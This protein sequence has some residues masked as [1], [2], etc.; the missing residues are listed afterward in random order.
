[1]DLI[2][3]NEQLA[4]KITVLKAE[5]NLLKESEKQLAKRNIAHQKV[6]QML[7]EKLRETDKM[8]EIAYENGMIED[9]LEKHA[10]AAHEEENKVRF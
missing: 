8:L 7:I 6:I 9:I 1:V 4:N 3:E 2:N 5:N 10:I